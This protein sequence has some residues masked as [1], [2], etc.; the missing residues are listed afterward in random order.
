MRSPNRTA[1]VRDDR[2]PPHNL[3]AE[4]SAIGGALVS[5]ESAAAFVEIV[6]PSDFYKAGHQ[7][8]AHAIHQLAAGEIGV[9]SVTVAEQLRKN[10]LLAEIG[11][12]QALMEMLA[13]TPSIS[14]TAHYCQIVADT[15]RLR[16]LLLTAADITELAYTSTDPAT[17]IPKAQQLLSGINVVPRAGWR[18]FASPSHGDEIELVAPTLLRR[19][20]GAF[21]LYDGRENGLQGEPASGKTWVA[22]AAAAEIL[23]IGG[24]VVAIDLEDTPRAARG[25]L[26]ALGV[27]TG[28]LERFLHTDARDV[29]TAHELTLAEL[30][31]TVVGE[32]PD[33]VLID[34]VSEAYSR[35][36][37]DEDKADDVNTFRDTL[38]KPLTRAGITVISLDH[39]AKSVEQ[40][41]RY[42]RGSGAKLSGLDG[43]AYSVTT[44]GFNRTTGGRIYLKVAKDRHGALPGVVGDTVAQIWMPATIE[45]NAID[46]RVEV[47]PPPPSKTDKTSTRTAAD[48]QLHDELR[49]AALAVIAKAK[50]PLSRRELLDQIR[51]RRRQE[52]LVGFDDKKIGPPLAD[53][54]AA[55]EIATIAGKAGH[56]AYALPSRQRSLLDGPEES[57]G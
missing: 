25:R 34:S 49:A 55:G 24:T 26:R 44:S 52:K 8:I 23:E 1:P 57:T 42:A 14:R 31:A 20:D 51:S 39:V 3:E 33:L 12:H 21:L 43:A 47:P 28:Q 40:R 27:T 22:L 36:R 15:S 11:G 5:V 46:Y 32:N 56:P 45:G 7:H 54:V 10:G 4:A 50:A 38:V 30:A 35:W 13:D 19:T 16:R 37:L 29:A 17:A 9:D 48:H 6:E 2:I 18:I 41:G 53:L